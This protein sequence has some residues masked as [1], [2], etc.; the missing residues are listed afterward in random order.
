MPPSLWSLLLLS[1]RCSLDHVMYHIK[2]EP[3]SLLLQHEELGVLDVCQRF[4]IEDAEQRLVIHSHHEFVTAEDKVS[5]PP[6]DC[7]AALQA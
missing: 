3:Q 6:L 1:W 4:V 2:V 5:H 7:T